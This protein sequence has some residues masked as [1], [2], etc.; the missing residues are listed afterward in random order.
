MV[1]HGLV[2]D[3][4]DAKIV[5][6]FGNCRKVIIPHL[7]EQIGRMVFSMCQTIE[8]VGFDPDSR[9]RRFGQF[10][11]SESLLKRIFIDSE[12]IPFALGSLN[13]ERQFHRIA[14]HESRCVLIECKRNAF[15]Q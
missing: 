13:S 14:V 8:E 9:L 2:Q 15:S 10:A 12:S 4:I 5:L 7:I 1:G 11:F 6:Y 3:V